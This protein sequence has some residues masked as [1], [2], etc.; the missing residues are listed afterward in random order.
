MIV[1]REASSRRCPA[2]PMPSNKICRLYRC[3]LI[4]KEKL[5]SAT[6]Q[7]TLSRFA[8]H[9][10]RRFLSAPQSELRGGL[11]QQHRQAPEALASG[12]RSFAHEARRCRVIDEIV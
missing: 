1:A 8:H 11:G 12:L 2:R 4:L 3:S 9:V 10:E 7:R 6:L 5:E